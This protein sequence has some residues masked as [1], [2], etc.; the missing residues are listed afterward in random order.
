MNLDNSIVIKKNTK[1]L[2]VYF[3]RPFVY[4]RYSVEFGLNATINHKTIVKIWGTCQLTKIGLFVLLFNHKPREKTQERKCKY[5]SIERILF[6]SLWLFSWLRNWDCGRGWRIQNPK[7]NPPP[8]HPSR[9]CLK[10]NLPGSTTKETRGGGCHLKWKGT[11]CCHRQE[12]GIQPLFARVTQIFICIIFCDLPVADVAAL[13]SQSTGTGIPAP[14]L[15]F[16][17]IWCLVVK[18]CYILQLLK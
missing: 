12:L 1:K 13:D 2:I 4:W 14:P 6:V 9:T 5:R 10:H 8:T 18:L 16:K 11:F 3:V 15:R 7:R 17:T